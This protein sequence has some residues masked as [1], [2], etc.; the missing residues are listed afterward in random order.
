MINSS[1][2]EERT[3]PHRR[4]SSVANC[5]FQKCPY[6][7]PVCSSS[8]LYLPLRDGVYISWLLP[9]VVLSRG[10]GMGLPRLDHKKDAASTWLSLK[11][12]I[13]GTQSPC[14][15]EAQTTQRGHSQLRSQPTASLSCQTCECTSF[16]LIIIPAPSLWTFQLR[17]QTSRSRDKS[18]PQCSAQ[19]SD[20]RHLWA[21][22][23][24]LF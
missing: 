21:F 15:E 1:Q 17:L 4:Q 19:I 24:L 12:L 6:Y 20:P 18:F 10:D 8:R 23:R 16:L 9:P 22:N 7:G 3:G 13:L 5:I 11:T 2:P 14:C